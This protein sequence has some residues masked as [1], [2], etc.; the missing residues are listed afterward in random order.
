MNLLS[1]LNARVSKRNV[2]SLADIILTILSKTTH[3]FQYEI[4]KIRMF[5]SNFKYV[6]KPEMINQVLFIGILCN[7]RWYQTAFSSYIFVRLMQ[8]DSD[9][10]YYYYISQQTD[11]V[12]EI[13]SS[14]FD[15]L[16]KMTKLV[17]RLLLWWL[18]GLFRFRFWYPYFCTRIKRYGS[19]E[20][21]NYMSIF[22]YLF[23]AL[24]SNN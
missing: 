21:Q 19:I 17:I 11:A 24:F 10:H 8:N 20:Q 14:C 3:Q 13:L 7:S 15:F 12:I 22:H 6:R 16:L 2:F 18:I 1:A 9:L 23:V 5:I 4:E